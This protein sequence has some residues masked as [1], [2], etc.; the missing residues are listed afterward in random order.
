[1]NILERDPYLD[2]LHECLN[3]VAR[4]KGHL[5]F[6]GGD[7]GGGKTALVERFAETIRQDT[8]V[9]IVSCDGLKMP[10]PLGPLFDIAEALGPEVEAVL[11][12]QAPRDRIFRTVLS[13]LRGAPG[14]NVLV[15]E[16]AHWTDEASLEL[17]R[18]LGRR[19]GTTRTLFIVT[20]RDDALNPY[21]PL[22]RILG[23]LVNEPAVSRIWLPPLTVNAVTT[24]AAGSGIDPV[25]LH[26]RT[27]GNPFY[28][29]EI[30]AAGGK[31]IPTSIR[32]AVLG[33]ASRISM[34]SRAVLDAAATIGVVTDPELLATMIG[35]PIADAVDECLAVGMFRPFGDKIAFR[36]GLTRE[37]FLQ[38]M[39]APR[40]MGLHCRIL[41]ILE[42]DPAFSADLAHL[43]HHAEEAGNTVAVLRYAL[44]AARQAVA[45]G[46]HREAAAQFGRTLRFAQ[47][48]PD[49][50]V[51][52]LLE[53]RSYECYLTGQLDDAIADRTRAVSLWQSV[54]D[55]LRIGA[56]MCWLSR[57]H[58]FSGHNAEAN[59]YARSALDL[60]EPLPPG[61]ELAMAF[62]NLSQIHLLAYDLHEAIRWGERAIALATS[63]DNLPILANALTNVGTARM[64][65][66]DPG[67]RE[68]I[69]R[70]LQIGMDLGLDD[71]ILRAY[72]NLS[73]IALD[74]CELDN[75]EWAIAEG[76]AFT[77]ERDFVAMEIYLKATR[78]RAWL[79]RGDWARAE[80]E[81]AAASHPS[82]TASARIV[83]LTALGLLY[84]RRGDD[85]SA[86]L[87]EAQNLA[88]R[89][90]Q[91][92]RLGPL[93]AAR[94]EAAWLAGDPELA[95]AEASMEYA[96]VMQSGER[97]LAGNLALWLHRGGRHI[98]DTSPL[99]EPFA[100]EI[101]GDGRAAA[102]RWHARGYPLE[103]ARALA[104]AGEEASLREALKIVER[105]GAKPDTARI[106]RRLRSTGVTNIPRGPRPET[107]ANAAHL[108]AR[109]LDVLRLLTLGHSNREIAA[110]LYLSPR[111]VGHHVSAI[112]GKLQI[113]SR[114]E[115]NARV[116]KLDLFPDRSSLSPK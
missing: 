56:S 21:H 15:G 72:A 107:Q 28:V 55:S 113:S 53:A 16:D 60:L 31:S 46:A 9:A 45:Y 6:L 88:E 92:L 33:R 106:V 91:L 25:S 59:H 100:L 41:G 57:F 1:M 43:A 13:A 103:E 26:E 74:H 50:E 84:A 51:A 48:L 111:T 77:F 67:G 49:E 30:V 38:S 54:R 110:T 68:L 105:L 86:V 76:L 35:A 97:W 93:R 37:V 58:W 19:I 96:N 32:D 104:S 18:F 4:G 61:S 36:H 20:Y 75:A 64:L 10:G 82:A 23:D 78:A 89:S 81:A 2:E 39:S 112:L 95:V 90:V 14:V 42:R 114:T 12:A 115:A 80:A 8:P 52:K 98:D 108:T 109:E 73:W 94:A 70:S 11:N 40:R 5:V 85:P 102:Q 22:R 65:S 99:A 24:L 7:A 44:A 3:Q 101:S 62:S 47:G 83:A 29:T 66:F 34:E 63:L 87:D 79:A 17:I 27:G 69:G 71:D 116:V